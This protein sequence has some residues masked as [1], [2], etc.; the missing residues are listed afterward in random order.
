MREKD[1]YRPGD[2][3]IYLEDEARIHAQVLANNSDEHCVQYE[4]EVVRTES[5]SLDHNPLYRTDTDLPA[6]KKGSLLLS[7]GKLNAYLHSIEIKD[8]DSQMRQLLR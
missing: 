5:V 8:I 1:A 3:I 6:M 4:L 7:I 2:E